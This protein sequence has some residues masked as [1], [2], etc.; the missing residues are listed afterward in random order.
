MSLLDIESRDCLKS[1]LD[2]FEI[3]ATQTSIGDSFYVNYYPISS[4]DRGGGPIEFVVRTSDEVYIDL[5]NT[6]LYTKSRIKKRDGT[7]IV[8]A[9]DDTDTPATVVFP[10]NYFHGTQFKNVEVY[11]NGRLASTSDN[12]SAYRAYLETLLTFSREAKTDQ[13]RCGLFYEDSGED[14]DEIEADITDEDAT[15]V[16]NIGFHQRFTRTKFSKLFETWGRVHSE[17]FSQS[18]ML[19]GSN[20]LRIKFHRNDANFSLISKTDD[21]SY[22]VSLE[23]AVL[24]V[25]HCQISA[26]VRESHAKALQIR[27]MKYPLCKVEMKFFTRGSGRSDLT[28][29]NLVSGVLPKRVVVGLVRSDA[30][31]GAQN[32]NPFNFQ[33][34]NVNSIVLRK[35]GFPMPVEE[36]ELDYDD[37]CYHQGYL[38]LVTGTG[39]LFQDQ[40]FAISPEQYK[41]G[42][43]LY[44]FDLTSSAS[45]CE[46]FD[47]VE[48]GKLSLEIKLKTATSE[49]VTTVV[50]LEYDTILELDK[51]GNI[52]LNE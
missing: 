34:F 28:E 43:A 12:L 7:K 50:Y 6:I 46:S 35:N 32:K 51:E 10:T 38:S 33:H 44:A 27:N 17:L 21:T 9:T 1:E 11:I 30:F 14:L 42:Y 25:K 5:K 40:G 26:H 15:E 41:N 47:L 16:E 48:D 3:P 22:M 2:L 37:D 13:L 52:H 18:K 8:E 49:S 36:V 20:E 29:P 23:E 39:K 45:S 24:K 19:P 4:V 31:N